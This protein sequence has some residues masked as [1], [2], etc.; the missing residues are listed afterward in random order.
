[1][2]TVDLTLLKTIEIASELLD[3]HANDMQKQCNKTSID[4]VKQQTNNGITNMKNTSLQNTQYTTFNQNKNN[5]NNCKFCK[6]V[7]EYKKCPAFGKKCNNCGR[8][9]HF[10]IACYSSKIHEI[11][12]NDEIVLHN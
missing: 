12:E 8:L 7:H 11:R 4:A 1:M 2:E 9:N 10:S 3:K 5:K 6:G